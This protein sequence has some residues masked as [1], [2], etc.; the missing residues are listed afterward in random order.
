MA[1]SFEKLTPDSKFVLINAH[2]NSQS[3]D[4]AQA[5]RDPKYVK[6]RHQ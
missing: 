6:F 3:N 5:L 2:V 1:E 4:F